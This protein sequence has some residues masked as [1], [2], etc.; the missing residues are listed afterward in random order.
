MGHIRQA[1]C[2]GGGVIGAGWVA[3]LLYNGID[4]V[5]CDPDP[6]AQNKV[7]AVCANADRALN[8]LTS[9]P[10]P[11]RG[12]LTFAGD[13][14]EAAQNADLVVEAV[15]ERLDLK[16]S[17]YAEIEKFVSSNALVASST[18]GILPSDLQAEMQHP[19]RLLVAHPF[20]PV[21]LLPLVELVGGKLTAADTISRASEFYTS[22][23]MRPLH[24]KKEIEAF[25]ADRLLEAVW[26]ESLWLVK[27]GIASTEEIDDAIRFGFGLRWAQM[28]LFE[29]YRI[30]GGEAG[31][32]HF[33]EQFGPCLKWP[34][35]KLTDVPDLDDQLV[36]LIAD[37]SDAQSGQ[38][39]IRELERIRDDNLVA[40]IKALKTTGWGAGQ[41]LAGYERIL[42]ERH[43]ATSSEQGN[44][45]PA[46][47][48]GLISADQT[49]QTNHVT[50]ARC[51]Q[52]FTEAR[53]ALLHS[54]GV[55]EE[56][57]DQVGHYSCLETRI[58][59]FDEVR[60]PE[61]VY[62]T[63]QLISVAG[64]DLQL[65]HRLQ[66]RQGALLATCEHRLVH[67]DT[68]TGNPAQPA[69]PVLNGLIAISKAHAG[70]PQPDAEGG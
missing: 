70:L 13:I 20:N 34:W 1:A 37:Q 2:I 17:V 27:D 4:V 69:L 42:L 10:A 57:I 39:P 24:V 56:Y 41:T 35:T 47:F 59:R 36:G 54:N 44:E 23:G 14:G 66:N 43:A 31:M 6:L 8:K 9:A 52:L 63:S 38:R 28:G 64:S 25:V 21:Y 26:R 19:H 11:D 5:V 46:N 18:S 15:P 48:E 3:R 29:T 55:D 32:Q 12:Q 53:D 45:P 65:F 22:I 51:L 30:A 60:A 58:R 16:R 49:D 67:I 33:L 7:E 61:Q 68:A 50:E 40:I 62:V